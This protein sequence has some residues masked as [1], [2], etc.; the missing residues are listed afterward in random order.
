MT[1]EPA[2]PIEVPGFWQWLVTADHEGDRGLSNVVNWWL[3]LHVSLAAVLASLTTTP[4]V[5]V[6]KS[7]ALPGAAIL[8]GLAFGWAGRSA[9]LFQDAAFSQFILQHSKAGPEGYIYSFQLA[10]LSVLAFIAVALVILS[11]GLQVSLGAAV[12][13]E[14]ANR[15]VLYLMGS[16][17][18]R[19]SWGIIYFVNKL[20][21]LYYRL[22]EFEISET[23]S[24]T[25]E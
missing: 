14:F 7:V 15:F 10:I 21:L 4:A 8:I 20:T 22:R 6:A 12:R 16:I 23:G 1:N 19:E 18:V 25:A 5:E 24:P 17:A 9:S 13:D 3:F 2:P 11:G